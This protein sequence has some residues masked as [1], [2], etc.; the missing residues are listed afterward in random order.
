MYADPDP[1]AQ[2]NA[3]PDPEPWESMTCWCGSGSGSADP[4]LRLMD[5]DLD[6]DPA[7]FG[8]NLQ[9][10]NK[11][12]PVL[13]FQSLSADY[14]KKVHLNNFSKIKSQKEVTKQQ[15]SRVFL[16]FLLDDS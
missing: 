1:A 13:G 9:D 15:E 6:A 12:I 2:I 16:L 11:K 5:P 10:A 4:C 8:I 3:D 7:I 14:F